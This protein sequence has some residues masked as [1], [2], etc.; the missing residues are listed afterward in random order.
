MGG[1]RICNQMFT[2][3]VEL[4]VGSDEQLSELINRRDNGA[5]HYGYA[6][7][8]GEKQSDKNYIER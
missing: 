2:D 7:Q 6:N 4:V 1:R 5:T 8:Y 3:D